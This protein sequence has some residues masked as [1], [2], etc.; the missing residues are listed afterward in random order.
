MLRPSWIAFQGKP[1]RVP[2]VVLL[3]AIAA[4]G[5]VVEHDLADNLVVSTDAAVVTAA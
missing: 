1:G 4:D 2:A 3:A 5:V